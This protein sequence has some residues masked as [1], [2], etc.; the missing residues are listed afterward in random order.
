MARRGE[1][2]LRGVTYKFAGGLEEKLIRQLADS[3]V[4]FEY[5]PGLIKYTVPARNTSYKP[6]F[7]LDNGIIVEGKGEFNSKERKKFA[8]LKERYPDLDIRFVFSR[9]K[10]K[11]GKKSE[12]TYAIWCERSGFPYADKTVPEAWMSE[13]ADP[14]RIAAA[15]AAI[16]RK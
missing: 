6:D 15:E 4:K 8:A 7:L 2:T 13:P 1:I 11:I 16:N 9:S 12:T 10:A 14:K 3:N 5:E